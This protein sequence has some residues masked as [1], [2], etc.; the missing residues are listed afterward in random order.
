M[1]D[2]DSPLRVLRRFDEGL[3]DENVEIE[4]CVVGGAVIALAFNHMSGTRRPGALFAPAE[5]ALRARR[6]AA[7]RSGVALDR[8]EDAAR[9]LV[10]ASPPR[11]G[12]FE[13]ERLRVFAPPPDYVLAMKCSALLFAPE[14]SVEDDVRYLLRFL[15]L[16]D[17][18]AALDAVSGY[19]NPRQRPDDLE[20]RFTAIL[21]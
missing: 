5:A 10:H 7:E 1:T 17:P 4:L 16:R 15:G 2:H 18:K 3:E 21:A 8:L 6:N 11:P 9:K 20:T 19:L 12:S 13:G 14:V